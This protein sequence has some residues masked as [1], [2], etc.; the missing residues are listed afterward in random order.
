MKLFLDA[1]A[2]TPTTPTAPRR[3]RDST[4][5]RDQRSHA[6]TDVGLRAT[7]PVDFEMGVVGEEVGVGEERHEGTLSSYPLILPSH[8]TLSS[9]PFIVSSHLP[10]SPSHL[11]LSSHPLIHF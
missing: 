3:P 2:S 6:R 4:S 1:D 8:L 10:L 7:C 11:T 9:Y 5:T